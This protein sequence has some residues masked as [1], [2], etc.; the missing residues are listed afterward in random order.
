MIKLT[1]FHGSAHLF[2]AIPHRYHYTDRH[3]ES[4]G[5]E[6]KTVAGDL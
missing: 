3:L 4:E 2:I 1:L 6:L 5:L